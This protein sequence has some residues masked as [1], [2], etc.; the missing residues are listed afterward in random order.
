VKVFAKRLESGKDD[1]E[2]IFDI[3]SVIEVPIF[4]GFFI[5]AIA[6]K[7]FII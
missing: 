3:S 1:I 2:A 6:L 7:C 4:L 5:Y